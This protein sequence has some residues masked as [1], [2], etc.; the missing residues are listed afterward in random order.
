MWVW[1]QK[2]GI[3]MD[4]CRVT[5]IVTG[6]WALEN[7]PLGAVGACLLLWLQGALL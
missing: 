6:I 1:R 2:W 4:E 7:A 5:L 3:G